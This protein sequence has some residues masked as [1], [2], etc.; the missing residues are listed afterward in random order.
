MAPLGTTEVDDLIE[1]VRETRL[2]TPT[3]RKRIRLGAGVTLREMAAAME[4]T[5]M[6]VLRWERGEVRPGSDN[7]RAYRSL[8]EAL[9]AAQR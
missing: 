6:T 8:L 5:P 1:R 2:P 3:T 9:Q 4:V 7:A